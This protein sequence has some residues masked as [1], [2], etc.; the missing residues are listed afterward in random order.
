MK[1]VLPSNFDEILENAANPLVEEAVGEGR[2]AIGYS[3]SYVPEALLSV[4]GLF[5]VRLRAPGV[6]ATPM[7]DTY[8]SSVVCPYPRSLLESA[9]EDRYAF[10]SG[11]VFIASCD[12]LRRL[13]DNLAYLLRPAFNYIVDLPHKTGD[14]ALSWYVEELGLLAEALAAHF[15][16]DTGSAALEKSIARLNEQ[17]K[18]LRTIGDL[19]R[20]AHPPISGSD[21]HRLFAASAAAPRDKLTAALR[22]IACSLAE[23]EGLG[24]SRARLMVVGSQLDDPAYLEV[25]E[26]TGGLVVADRFCFGSLPGLEPIPETGDPLRALAE[27]TLRKTRCPRM[28]ADF[29]VRLHDIEATVRAFAVDGVVVESM[30][31][32][33]IWGYEA[34]A[35]AE[36]L[37]AAGIPV[38][39]VEREYARGGE[40]QLRTRVQAFLESMGK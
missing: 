2:A 22:A 10:L 18:V 14:A 38:L 31:F 17:L 29:D 35:L 40:G 39:R 3:C 15:G 1:P 12:H 24:A 16:V 25:I 9:L 27:H 33:D 7:A 11:W 32:C 13:Y 28:M 26:S 5:P 30:K 4:D 34:A 6:A 37:R 21:F 19:R 8:L 20:R 23:H 36:A